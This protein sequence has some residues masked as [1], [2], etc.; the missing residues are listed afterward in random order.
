MEIPKRRW[1]SRNVDGPDRMRSRPSRARRFG[2]PIRL[3]EF[4]VA[5][6]G[7]HVILAGH[8][9]R[10]RDLVEHLVEVPHGLIPLRLVL[11]VRDPVLTAE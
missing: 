9:H 11:L 3:P 1:R 7:S 8:A 2:T 5:H 6:F 4:G 10:I